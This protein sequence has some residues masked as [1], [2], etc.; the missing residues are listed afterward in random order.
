MANYKRKYIPLKDA[1][2]ISGYTVSELRN[3][4]KIGLISSRKVKNKIQVP[5]SAF[6]KINESKKSKSGP[7]VPKGKLNS[8]RH[9]AMTKKPITSIIPFSKPHGGLVSALEHTAFAAAMVFS[10]Y[11]GMLPTVSEKIVFGV[12]LAHATIDQMSESVL[13]MAYNSVAIPVGVGSKLARV[14]VSPQALGYSNTGVVAGAATSFSE[15]SSL[16]AGDSADLGEFV[17]SIL[18]GI[19]DASDSLQQKLDD[20]A[21]FTDEALIE[22]FQFENLD[23]GIQR[24]FRL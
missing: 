18:I 14:A 12:E 8:T 9:T 2:I 4:I 17:T 21:E 22:S 10:L 24:F 15:Q 13:D 5:F 1:A 23:D 6:E 19:A 20:L 11:M 3:F 7:S 16:E